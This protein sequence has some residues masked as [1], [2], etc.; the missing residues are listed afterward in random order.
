MKALHGSRSAS[1]LTFLITE[2]GGRARVGCF[3]C[4]LELMAAPSL[5]FKASNA[6]FQAAPAGERS[7]GRELSRL[8]CHVRLET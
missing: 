8:K 4:L 2:V 5:T 7:C 1:A 3:V 6:A